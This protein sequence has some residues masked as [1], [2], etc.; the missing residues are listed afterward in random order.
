VILTVF[1]VD[2]DEAN[3]IQ[4][5]HMIEAALS[6]LDAAGSPPSAMSY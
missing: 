5:K 1:Q 3:R 2:L 4:M 6:Q